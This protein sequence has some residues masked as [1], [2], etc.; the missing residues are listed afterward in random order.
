MYKLL[1]LARLAPTARAENGSCWK[2]DTYALI[3]YDVVEVISMYN[4]AAKAA[5]AKYIKA[6]RD[7][8]N[9]NMPKG[10]KDEY[11]Q[12]AEAHGMSLNAYIISLLERDKETPQV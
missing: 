11:R 4:E 2:L 8:L 7:Q 9:L 1:I 10:K 6:K 12:Q 3:C 5:S